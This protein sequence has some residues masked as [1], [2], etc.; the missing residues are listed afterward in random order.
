MSTSTFFKLCVRAPRTFITPDGFR[1]DAFECGP[2]VQMMAGERAALPQS[3]DGA[4][5]DDLA[6]G[7][8]GAGTKVDDVIGN[9]DRLRLVL[10]NEHAVALV[11][12][13]QQQAVHPL[14]VVRMQSDRRL[15]EDV[16]HVSER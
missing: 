11:A 6:A 5:E 12:Q 1:T 16:G 14:N 13:P 10:D 4:L 9:H 15:V 7:G 2:V 3:V 8:T